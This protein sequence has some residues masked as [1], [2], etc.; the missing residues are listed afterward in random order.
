[1]IKETLYYNKGAIKTEEIHKTH[2][3]SGYDYGSDIVS[4][5][6]S[7]LF[8]KA[9][10]HLRK[11]KMAAQKDGLVVGAKVV[12]VEGNDID[13]T[14][15]GTIKE[16]VASVYIAFVHIKDAENEEPA[17]LMV[18]YQSASGYNATRKCRMS[19]VMLYEEEINTGTGC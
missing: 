11:A 6:N 15:I 1:M 19:E 10:Y 2:N 16:Y 4:A 7:D 18:E 14:K 17:F 3:Y 5:N 13:F 8:D 9:N 12:F